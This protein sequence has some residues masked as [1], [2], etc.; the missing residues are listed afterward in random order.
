V[1][2]SV[3]CRVRRIGGRYYLVKEW[4]DPETRRKKIASLGPCDKIE[5]ILMVRGVGFEPTQAYAIGA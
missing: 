4:Y 3:F 1:V 5:K 2:K